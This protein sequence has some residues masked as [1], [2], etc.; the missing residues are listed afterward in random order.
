MSKKFQSVHLNMNRRVLKL[1]NFSRTAIFR[2]SILSLYFSW[3]YNTR[4][5]VRN[6]LHVGM[7]K[8]PKVIFY[9]VL[10]ELANQVGELR[11]CRD[12]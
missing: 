10:E 1:T 8:E 2:H 6:Y 9:A 12:D 3:Q 11:V 4:L 7:I 5:H